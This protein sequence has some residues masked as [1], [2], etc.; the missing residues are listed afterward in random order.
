MMRLALVCACVLHIV[1][2]LVLARMPS[3]QSGASVTAPEPDVE[4]D[5]IHE[6]TY[7]R[8]RPELPSS[9]EVGAT[10]SGTAVA[11]AI[12]GRHEGPALKQG[13]DDG[14]PEEPAHVPTAEDGTW[15]FSP[16]V[17]AIDLASSFRKNAVSAMARSDRDDP[18]GSPKGGGLVEALD[19]ADL[20]KGIAHG[21]AVKVAIDEIA[22]TTNAPIEGNATFSIALARTGNVHVTL[23][24]AN[25][26]TEGWRRLVFPIR[27]LVEEKFHA[28]EPMIVPAGAR[29]IKVVVR[30]EAK[31]QFVDG[32]DPKK[33]V[34][35]FARA[36]PGG[37][38]KTKEGIEILLPAAS[39]GYAG[40][41]CSV[42][43][44]LNPGG[45]VA[46][47]H[48][49]ESTAIIRMVSSRIL[50]EERF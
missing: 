24:N 31:Q 37:I 20:A 34:G 10:P 47:G 46:N 1:L 42:A 33:A 35:A 14:G 32:G 8:A 39:V 23:M 15:S 7:D 3:K 43:I 4:L 26:E 29:G 27:K 13:G 36:T 16:T 6:S 50:T 9:P 25:S 38:K 48:C 40:R 44:G 11:R 18:N 12:V 2:F 22:R 21:G 45:I 19:A 49:R 41:A 5:I 17:G 30:V 28:K